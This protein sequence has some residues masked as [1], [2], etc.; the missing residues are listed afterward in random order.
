MGM[1]RF[2]ATGSKIALR[3]Y[4]C[5]SITFEYIRIYTH[6]IAAAVLVNIL[7]VIIFVYTITIYPY[8]AVHIYKY[9]HIVIG[10]YT[11]TCIYNN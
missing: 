11:S 9:I 6:A 5:L 2:A 4:R 1:L 8:L 3:A 10:S 7:N